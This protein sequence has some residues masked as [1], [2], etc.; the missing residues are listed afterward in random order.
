MSA[1]R[2][3]VGRPHLD[4]RGGRSVQVAIRF[5][6]QDYETLVR[7]LQEVNKRLI[8]DGLPGEINLSTLLRFWIMDR[9][10]EEMGEQ[11][12]RRK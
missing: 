6:E 12:K 4:K 5:G 10:N 8:A 7:A 2:K 9:L 1:A 3:T 11:T